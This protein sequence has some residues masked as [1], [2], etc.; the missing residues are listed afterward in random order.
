MEGSGTEMGGGMGRLGDVLFMN[1]T[2]K[3]RRTVPQVEKGVS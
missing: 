1:P 3:N 2:K